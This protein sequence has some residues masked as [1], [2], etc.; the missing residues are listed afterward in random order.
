MPRR[1][2]SSW[3]AAGVAVMARSLARA[4]EAE[5]ARLAGL[6]GRA[7][8][9][10]REDLAG[11]LGEHAAACAAGAARARAARLVEAGQA[12]CWRCGQPIKAGEPFDLGHDDEDRSI[13]RGP[14]H[15]FCNRSAAGKAAHKYD[16]TETD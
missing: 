6:V 14:E 7:A 11:R 15:V 4:G 10:G 3:S 5:A 9:I 1:R 16:R 8:L 12:T 13:I 2:G